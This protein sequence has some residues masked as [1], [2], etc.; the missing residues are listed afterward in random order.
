MYRNRKG[1]L[2]QTAIFDLNEI[3]VVALQRRGLGQLN[4]LIATIRSDGS[5]TTFLARNACG[6]G[7]SDIE[8]N[9]LAVL[10]KNKNGGC[11]VSRPGG[12]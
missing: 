6:R 5:S 8:G 4:S 10:L 7:R 3:I 2:T 11:Q 1:G 9:A 12:L